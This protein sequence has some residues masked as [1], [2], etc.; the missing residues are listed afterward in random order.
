MIPPEAWR[1]F[2]TAG[3][4]ICGQWCRFHL[5]T[6]VGEY[7]I[8]TV[9]EYVH[10]SYSGGS[11]AAEAKWLEKNWPGADIGLGRKYETM[12]FRAGAP[13]KE[14]DCKCGQPAIGGAELGTR[15]YNNRAD[16]TRGHM[17]LCREWADPVR[18]KWAELTMEPR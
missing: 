18:R 1:W 6:Q 16:A 10:P 2:G 11:E 17:E 5:C 9:G 13:C 12:V 7:L 15:G 3:H 4:F 14:A 8:S